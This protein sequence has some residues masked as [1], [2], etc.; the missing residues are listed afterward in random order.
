MRGNQIIIGLAC[1][2]ALPTLTVPALAQETG[3]DGQ[4]ISRQEYD[5]LKQMFEELK[6]EFD[7]LR[8]KEGA[9]GDAE[10][11]VDGQLPI[12]QEM[13]QTRLE[14]QAI[15]RLAESLEPGFS[16]FLVTGYGHTL[17]TDGEGEDSS[18]SALF[19]PVFLWEINDR[20]LFETEIAFTFSGGGGH[21]AMGGG[22]PGTEVDLEYAHLSY[23]LNDYVTIGAGK[24]LTP[25]SIF[26]ERLHPSWINKLPNAP[27]AF[28]H[29]GIAPMASLGAYIRGGI[30]IG[31]TKINYA[32][33][34][35]NGPRLNTGDDEPDEAG[36]LHFDNYSD[37]N[38]NKAIGG[39]I[40]FL[41]IPEA[42]FGYSF[43]VAGVTP[44]GEIAEVGD[45]DA[46]LQAIDFSYVRDIDFLAGMIDFRFEFAW[47][48]VDTT[49]YELPGGDIT[50][51]N[52]RNGGYFQLAY[53]PINVDPS[54]LQ[55]LEVVGRWDWLDGPA[56]GPEG[57]QDSERWAL[58]LNYW[59][60]PST[61]LKGS[62][63]RTDKEGHEDQDAF[64]FM[65]ST[66]F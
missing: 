9:D 63:Q 59:L 64:L 42:E 28:A 17:F 53:R 12:R 26:A 15:R 50:F 25:F 49:T 51:D 52:E 40:G 39:R 13:A 33:Y 24:F 19:A 16:N 38:N 44:T 57:D 65:F 35:S 46:F 23:L 22:E 20:L 54:F 41:P 34:V 66:G 55:D 60:T 58:G 37:V 11:G 8:R 56:G 62:F 6:A 21:G 36:Q 14:L 4:Y 32:F 30:P 1:L 61:V 45:V 10:S 7:V 48:D 43:L 2:V 31:S 29:G 18:F 27:M 47:S 5:A 3:Q